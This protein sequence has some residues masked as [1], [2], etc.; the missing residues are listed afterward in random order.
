MRRAVYLAIV[1]W[2]LRKGWRKLY[3]TA[4]GILKASTEELKDLMLGHGMFGACVE[5][6]YGNRFVATGT[7]LMRRDS[8][9]HVEDELNGRCTDHLREMP[10]F[11]R[12]VL[13]EDP[14]EIPGIHIMS[15]LIERAM[16]R[17]G[18]DAAASISKD[19]VAMSRCI[20]A[21]ACALER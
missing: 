19:I 14:A 3:R 2:F 11:R 16:D 1:L 4:D 8:V 6:I 12:V 13:L 18:D 21:N 17:Y 15:E 20:M 9:G 7:V 5:D 10:S